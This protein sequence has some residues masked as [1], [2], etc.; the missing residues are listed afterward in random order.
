MGKTKSSKKKSTESVLHPFCNLPKVDRRPLPEGLNPIRE[1][2]IRVVEKKWANGTQLRYYFFD[3]PTDGGGRWKGPKKQQDV[4]RKAFK[5]WKDLGIGLEFREVDTREE[6]EIRIGFDQRDG[7]WSYVGRDIIDFAGDPNERTMNFGWDL[8]TSYGWDTALHE[9]GHTLGFPHAH[10]N[11]FAGIDWDENAV[12][13]YFSGPPNYWDRQ[14]IDWNILRKLSPQEVEGSDWDPN[15]IM[16]YAFPAGM[17]L[18]PEQY[19]NGLEPE[20]GLSQ[21]DKDQVQDYAARKGMT[22]AE[23]ERWLSP[24]LAYDPD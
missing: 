2:L 3:R 12:Y 18:H 8:T 17:I 21:I 20:P 10:Q 4:V 22:L 6:A 14:T 13:N 5:A 24:V 7:S 19:R 1:R 15:S 11:P 23:A 16:Q 9:I